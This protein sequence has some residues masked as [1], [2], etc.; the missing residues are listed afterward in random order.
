MKKIFMF[1]LLVF[2]MTMFNL[3]RADVTPTACNCVSSTFTFASNYMF[4]G[5]SFS[6]HGS[7]YPSQGSPVIEGSVDYFKD[8][9]GVS[10]FTGNADTFN[11]K[12]YMMEPDTE[13]DTFVNYTRPITESLSLTA[14]YNYYSFIKN[15]DNDMGE[16]A[17]TINFKSFSVIGSYIDKYSGVD[18]NHLRIN[19]TFVQSLSEKVNGVFSFGRTDFKNPSAV[20]SSSYFDY[21]IGVQSIVEGFKTEIFYTNTLLRSDP[22]TD[23]YINNDGTFS[24]TVSKTFNI[25]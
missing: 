17:L 16:V 1:A 22:Y 8:N 19:T 15:V 11:T 25:L 24:V 6:S 3:G 10:F 18:T 9:I 13:A 7:S 12:F 21:H 5:M 20:A 4:R 2:S 23:K 14:G